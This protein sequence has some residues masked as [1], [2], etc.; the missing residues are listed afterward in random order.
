M[1]T[2]IPARLTS[3]A[4]GRR[5]ALTVGGMFVALAAVTWWR[6]RLEVCVV[7]GILGALLILAGLTIP[8]R[9][10]PV[11]RAW[12]GMAHLL[13]RVTT[14]MFLGIVFFVVVTPVGWL[15][16]LFGSRPLYR[17]PGSSAWITRP[18]DARRNS[19]MHRQ[20]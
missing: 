1:A 19:Q 17:P 5:F 7:F 16:R 3:D 2:G 15:K 6:G 14:P 18:P 12:M 9:L 8:T 10:G 20:F 13:S 11:S 4:A